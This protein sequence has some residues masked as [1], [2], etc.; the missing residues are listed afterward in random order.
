[1]DWKEYQEEIASLFHDLGCSVAIERTFE[2][3]RSSHRVD[4]LV[5]FSTFGIGQLW[6]IEGKFW[7]TPVT[8]EKVLALQKIVSDTGAD[9]GILVSE[10]GFQSGAV[11]AAT[12]TN[13]QL[14]NLEDLRNLSKDDLYDGM[15]FHYRTKS[16]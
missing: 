11:S 9:R 16:R 8:K 1:M 10:S 5:E 14:T 2:G 4:V 6:I 15:L 3:A 7:K 12:R 13:I